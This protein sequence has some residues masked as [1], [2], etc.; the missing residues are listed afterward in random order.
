MLYQMSY[1]PVFYQKRVVFATLFLWSIS[2][3]N[4]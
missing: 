4:R 2:E 3:S 1:Y